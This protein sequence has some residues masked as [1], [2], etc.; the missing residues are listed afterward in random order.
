MTAPDLESVVDVLELVAAGGAGAD[1]AAAGAPAAVSPSDWAVVASA[2]SR[3]DGALWSALSARGVTPSA[4]GRG[5]CALVC[6]R[7][8]GAALHAAAAYAQL[9]ASPGCPLFSLYNA[10]GFE[11]TLKALRDAAATAQLAAAADKRG[12]KAKAKA[13]KAAAQRMDVDGEDEPAAGDDDA[14]DADDEEGG[15]DAADEVSAA[16]AA[17]CGLA[18]L[19]GLRTCLASLPL[20]DQPDALKHTLDCLGA[21]AGSPVA[22][23]F[24]APALAVM[25]EL[26]APQ[27]G[28]VLTTAAAQCQRLSPALL[29]SSGRGSAGAAALEHVCAVAAEVAGARAAVA[30]LV[31]HLCL[32]CGERAEPRARAVDAAVALLAALPRSETAAFASFLGRLSR[33]PSA[34]H[35]SFAADLAP[36]LLAALPE[37]FAAAEPW[38]QEEDA[39]GSG[40]PTPAP[41]GTG[42]RTPG[43]ALGRTP[44]AASTGGLDGTAASPALPQG[45]T[46]GTPSAGP[47]QPWGVVCLQLLLQRASDRAPAVRAKALAGLAAAAG[48]APDAAEEAAALAALLGG[49]GANIISATAACVGPAGAATPGSGLRAAAGGATPGTLMFLR[50]CGAGRTPGGDSDGGS[51]GAGSGAASG[52]APPAPVCAE[53]GALLRLRCADEKSAVRRAALGALEAVAS[54]TSALC[55]ADVAA[56]AAACGD[57]LL[58][59]R[60]AALGALCRLLAAQPDAPGLASFWLAAALP[61]HADTESAVADAALD[62]LEQLLLQ[63][64]AAHNRKGGGA[65]RASAIAAADALLRALGEAETAGAASSAAQALS[66]AVAALARRGRIKAAPLAALQAR[67]GGPSCAGEPASITA[68]AWALLADLA[69]ALPNATD[70]E[71]LAA[72]W[73]AARAAGTP[74]APLLRAVAA[75]AGAFSGAAAARVATQLEQ[76]V[77][78]FTAPLPPSEA[79]AHLRALAPLAAR[80]AAAGAAGDGPA[81]AWA[82]RLLSAAGDALERHLH[83]RRDGAAASAAAAAL[84]AAGQTA[85][86]CPAAVRGELV[87]LVQA[88]VAG[89]EAAPMG[90]DDASASSAPMSAQEAALAAH[91]WAALSKLCL[92]DERLAKRCVPLFAREL[93]S[94]RAPAAVRANALLGLAELCAAHTALVEPHAGRLAAAARDPCELVRRQALLLLA[95]LLARDYLKFRGP[96]FVR[97]AAALADESPGV[98]DLAARLLQHPQ[99]APRVPALAYAHFGD[100]LFALHGFA[101]GSAAAAAQGRAPQPPP[102]EAPA[103]LRG[104]EPAARASRGG[105]L[106]HLLAAMTPEHRLATAAKLCADVLVPFA[107]GVLPLPSAGEVL[108]DALAALACRE[109]AF[110]AKPGGAGAVDDDD[111]GEGTAAAGAPATQGGALANARA[112]VVASLARRNLVD[113]FVPVLIELK[114]LLAAQHSPLLPHLLH[115]AR[116]TL[117]DLRAEL[118]DVLAADRQ[119][120]AELLHDLRAEEP[121]GQHAAKAAAAAAEPTREQPARRAGAR[122]RGARAR[123][124]SLTG[125]DAE[126]TPAAAEV[127]QRAAPPASYA[128]H[129]MQLHA[130]APMSVPRLRATTPR[131][132]G[133]HAVDAAALADVRR[134][135]SFSEATVAHA[136]ADENRGAPL[137]NAVVHL[138]SPDKAPAASPLRMP[139]PAALADAML[140]LEDDAPAAVP[141]PRGAKRVR[142]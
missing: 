142:A 95:G 14:M 81:D 122:A 12:R 103:A 136:F 15:A 125:V 73:D 42:G 18:T 113:N 77:A 28:D 60:R 130:G 2:A 23:G 7:G 109:M 1:G 69:E 41:P 27:H 99:L 88:L 83:A 39:P 76:R 131:V 32:R 45:A 82:R 52:C 138:F 120:A 139:A 85:L 98:R 127:L 118:D 135:Q 70:G 54:A 79:A 30:A 40:A 5:A 48:R 10:G 6:G 55:A 63:G 80:A 47:R 65:A 116:A 24:A 62:A 61:L 75:A 84:F 102:K 90:G 110:K 11:G 108:A 34:A 49:G 87:T 22:C 74:A 89:P 115:C 91:A 112:R 35:R 68:G 101:D 132:A 123:R 126:A 33:S 137:A 94:G 128:M 13:P 20:R 124:G 119:L 66:G 96:L 134:R 37:P 72:A 9:L 36:A 140:A 31:R 106:R 78:R 56:V 25:R 107:E 64:V 100:T 93:G 67:L 21:L 50:R 117:R 141:L 17:S 29:A 16:D 19:A 38:P 53:L 3:P 43:S 97:F 114:R 57:A 44:G 46:P 51:S 121:A 92:A 26:L 8:R 4:L 133:A 71:F 59:V 58:S 129:A 111:D 104:P 86:L 105:V